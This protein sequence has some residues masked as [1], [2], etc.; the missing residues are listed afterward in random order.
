MAWCLTEPEPTL[1]DHQRCS[2]AISLELVH[3]KSTWIIWTSFAKETNS[4][5]RTRLNKFC[6]KKIT[7]KAEAIKMSGILF[8]P[9]YFNSLLSTA[10]SPL[11]RVRAIYIL[12]M[13]ILGSIFDFQWPPILEIGRWTWYVLTWVVW[14]A[15]TVALVAGDS[16]SWPGTCT[17]DGTS[18]SGFDRGFGCFGLGCA[19]PIVGGFA[20]V[21]TV[22]L[23]LCVRNFVVIGG[24]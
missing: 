4:R 6:S 21:V 17:T 5:V 14:A 23:S 8:R 13:C 3:T 10:M 20:H 11:S 15:C 9:Q 16:Q 24:Q 12:V 19:R 22:I 18:G 1:T 2:L 7:I